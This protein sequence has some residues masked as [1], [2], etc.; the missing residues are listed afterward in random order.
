M[1]LGMG[2]LLREK[3]E[4]L[5]WICTIDLTFQ[6]RLDRSYVGFIWIS[7]TKN[8]GVTEEITFP[9]H[10]TIENAIPPKPIVNNY[11][12]QVI[13]EDNGSVS[14]TFESPVRNY[15]RSLSSRNS[16]SSSYNPYRVSIPT[17][18]RHSISKI[19]EKPKSPS[20]ES[21]NIE[22]IKISKNQFPYPIYKKD[23][24]TASDDMNFSIHGWVCNR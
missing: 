6:P 19:P 8:E 22:G 16:F 7:V 18:S 15:S 20:I 2:T 3:W 12:D 13:Q 24:P 21:I 14:I 4:I 5:I 23:S 11:I 9:E 10:W 1:Y 17:T